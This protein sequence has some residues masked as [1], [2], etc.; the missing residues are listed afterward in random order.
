MPLTAKESRDCTS[1]ATRSALALRCSLRD[2]TAHA[3]TRRDRLE[4]DHYLG[5]S[6]EAGGD[7]RDDRQPLLHRWQRLLVIQPSVRVDFLIA[8]HITHVSEKA[9]AVSTACMAVVGASAEGNLTWA[10]ASEEISA[11]RSPLT[12]AQARRETS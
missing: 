5:R 2:R 12:G 10:G 3:G 7:D 4:A 9:A 6:R 8:A 1:A 11:Q